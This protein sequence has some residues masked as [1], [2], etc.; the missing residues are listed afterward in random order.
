M[1]NPS[2]L[3]LAAV[4]AR[5]R[6]LGPGEL[7]SIKA[8]DLWALCSAAEAVETIRGNWEQ[9]LR[10]NA[11]LIHAAL[12]ERDE[13]RAELALLRAV[14][15]EQG[16]IEAVAEAANLRAQLEASQSDLAALRAELAQLK[17]ERLIGQPGVIVPELIREHED[18]E[19]ATLRAENE[20]L[21]GANHELHM[22]ALSAHAQ[23]ATLRERLA[24]SAAQPKCICG[25]EYNHRSVCLD[26]AAR[27]TQPEKRDEAE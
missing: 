24:T 27:T 1:T 20:R 22:E 13:V 9:S 17:A 19:F 15:G 18:W 3:D 10:S 8:D 5:M 12:S 25:L 7:E 23:C 26:D 4:V 21:K 14:H 2:P 11:N 6:K 16:R